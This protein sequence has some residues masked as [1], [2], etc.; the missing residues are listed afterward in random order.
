MGIVRINLI[1][2]CQSKKKNSLE[3]EDSSNNKIGDS[4][5]DNNYESP[6]IFE[7]NIINNKE[8]KNNNNSNF[9]LC[10][11]VISKK[12]LENFVQLLN[13]FEQTEK[14]QTNF[15]GIDNGKE[16]KDNIEIYIN[17]KKIDFCFKYKF[18]KGGKYKIKINCINPLQ[19]VNYMF[20]SC[21]LM[22]TI[23]LNNFDTN[24]ISNM[25]GLFSFCYNLI[26]IDLS[27]FNTNKVTDMSR[28]FYMCSELKNL[29]ITHFDTSN[30]TNMSGL[31]FNCISLEN[32]DL[33][34]LN[35]ENVIDMS[36]MFCYCSKIKKLDLSN[37]KTEKVEIM[38]HMFYR[39]SGLKTLDL[40][41][42]YTNNLRIMNEMFAEC[43]SLAFLD[44]SNFNLD[45][46]TEMNNL[47]YKMDKNCDIMSKEPKIK[48]I[49]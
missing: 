41:N 11:Y 45:N 46:V 48:K 5:N 25:S 14:V 34:K 12:A 3:Q 28:M 2:Q 17:D 22:K 36:Y 18:E 44:L 4:P 19:N 7:F 42:F 20:C 9:V 30:V 24:S 31:F 23:N 29:N 27:N 15:E 38:N 47:F 37:F 6:K 40:S 35:T 43:T 8:I 33:S 21:I 26:T 13:C 32:I 39:C 10:E 16:L 49:K 1:F